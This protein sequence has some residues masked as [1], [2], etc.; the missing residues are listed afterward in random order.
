MILQIVGL[1]QALNDILDSMAKKGLPIP[2]W[3]MR[4]GNLFRIK[5]LLMHRNNS[6]FCFVFNFVK[7]THFVIGIL[8]AVLWQQQAW[9]MF[10]FSVLIVFA[11]AFFWYKKWLKS[12]LS[13]FL[14]T[15]SK[16]GGY[17]YQFLDCNLLVDAPFSFSIVICWWIRLSVSR[18]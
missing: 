9:G 17:A 12:N 15:K 7:I 6:A 2:V 10:T 1:C 3:S 11:L 13:F 14:V 16:I 18:L 5:D 8:H 4:F